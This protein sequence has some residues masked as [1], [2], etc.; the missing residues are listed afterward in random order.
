M[1]TKKETRS[2]PIARVYI[3]TLKS[4][5]LL[6]LP[7]R[8]SSKSLLNIFQEARCPKTNKTT[9]KFDNSIL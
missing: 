1:L 8:R 3:I 9:K 7:T 5:H 6:K 4:L 2:I